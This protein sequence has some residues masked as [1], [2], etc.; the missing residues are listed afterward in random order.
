GDLATIVEWTGNGGGKGGSGTPGSGL[1]V[2]AETGTCSGHP[3]G[4]PAEA[5]AGD[6]RNKSGVT[7]GSNGPASGHTAD[8]PKRNV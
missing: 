7:K 4:R 1:S 6:T 8:K 5:V 2:S 3:S